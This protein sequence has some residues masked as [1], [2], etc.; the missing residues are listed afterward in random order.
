MKRTFS[1]IL[2]LFCATVLV[3]KSYTPK[4]N[5]RADVNAGTLCGSRFVTSPDL[6]STSVPPC[7]GPP[8]VVALGPVAGAVGAHATRTVVMTSTAAGIFR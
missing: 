6:A 2:L 5:T 8:L 3:A 1:V 7:L 4:K